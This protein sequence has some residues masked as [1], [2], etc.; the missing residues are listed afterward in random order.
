MS[1]RPKILLAVSGASGSIYAKLILDKFMKVYDQWQDLA[2]V[3]TDNAKEVWH[4][5]LENKDYDTYD[6]KR[7]DLKDFSAP[8]ASGS[9]Q[10]NIMIIAPC[11][12]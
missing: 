12:M 8:F 5:E 2:L 9:G 3:M 11:S 10:Y 1:Q 4:T 6:V 7:F